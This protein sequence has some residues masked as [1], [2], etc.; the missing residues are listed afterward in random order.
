MLLFERW[1]HL[2]LLWLNLLQECHI[3]KGKV[4]CLHDCY[5]VWLYLLAFKVTRSHI[6]KSLF[7]K[8]STF[9]YAFLTL[10]VLLEVWPY[11]LK[12]IWI[13]VSSFRY[14]GCQFSSVGSQI[15]I[16]IWFYLLY[17]WPIAWEHVTYPHTCHDVWDLSVDVLGHCKKMSAKL[18]KIQNSNY[19]IFN[20]LRSFILPCGG[21]VWD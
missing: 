4:T 20:C 3:A 9:H 2:F 5:E 7:Y 18:W 12:H 16:K 11:I 1:W 19:A 17:E 15:C 6:S 21:Q 8:N 13:K 14:H 10:Q